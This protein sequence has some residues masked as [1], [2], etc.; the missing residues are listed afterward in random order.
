MS[1]RVTTHQLEQLVRMITDEMRWAGMLNDSTKV[2]LD[3]GSKT[4]GR[5]YRLYTVNYDNGGG[6]SDSPLYLGDGFLGMTK[7]EAWLS[8][9]SILRAMEAVRNYGKRA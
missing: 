8:L 3:Q 9:R 4:Y 5:A 6:Y 7:R 2:V 1:E